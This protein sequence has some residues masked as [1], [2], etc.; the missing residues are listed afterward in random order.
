MNDH[1][2]RMLPFRSDCAFDVVAFAASA[3]GL[4][5]LS[6]ILSN[7][8]EN[9]PAAVLVVQHLDPKHKSLMAHIL[10][11]RTPLKTCEARDGDILET[12]KVFVAP[13]DQH[14]I[15]LNRGV[16]SLVHSDR[17]N[18]VRPSA[19]LLFVSV[20][21]AYPGRAVAVILSGTGSDG[22]TG[23]IAI[24]KSGGV[25]IAQDQTSSE[26]FGMPGASI[27]TGSVDFILPLEKIPLKLIE[28]TS[29]GR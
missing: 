11:R 22:S 21:S 3:G 28:L 6:S 26:Y 14:M 4:G 10:G 17:V 27:E 9:F 23:S 2:A 20:A 25:V 13:P 12:A 19:D 15:L 16:I 29:S 1:I 24:K 7:L 18:Y 8:P 5:A